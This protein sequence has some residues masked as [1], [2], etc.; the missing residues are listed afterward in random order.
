MC[1]IHR[2][3]KNA[4]ESGRSLCGR[5]LACSCWYALRRMYSPATA[6]RSTRPSH[7]HAGLRENSRHWPTSRESQSW[8]ERSWGSL[9]RLG[10]GALGRWGAGAR[11]DKTPGIQDHSRKVASCDNCGGSAG[12]D[13]QPILLRTE[14]H[15]EEVSITDSPRGLRSVARG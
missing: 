10:A 13:D 15:S 14:H 2:R 11:Q 5:T 3:R 9:G 6:L 8:S 4:E 12:D 7:L 1:T